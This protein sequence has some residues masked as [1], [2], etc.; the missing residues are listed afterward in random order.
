[1]WRKIIL[2]TALVAFAAV[3]IVAI[4]PVANADGGGGG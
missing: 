2:A 1:M 4:M 3:L